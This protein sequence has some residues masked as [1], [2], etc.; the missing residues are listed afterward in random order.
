M[1]WSPSDTQER[2]PGFPAAPLR[3]ASAVARWVILVALT[4]LAVTAFLGI[5]VSVLFTAIQNGL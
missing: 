3:K 4:A 2:G 5:V 1:T